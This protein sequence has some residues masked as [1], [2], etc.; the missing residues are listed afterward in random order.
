MSYPTQPRST[1]W[2]PIDCLPGAKLTES[3]LLDLMDPQEVQLWNRPTDLVELRTAV[4]DEALPALTF[5]GNLA[6]TSGKKWVDR[7][8][9]CLLTITTH[10][11]VLQQNNPETGEVINARYLH[12]SNLLA[13]TQ[14]EKGTMFKN[15]RL[16]LGSVLGEIYLIFRGDK[17]AGNCK[18]VM[19]CLQQ[20]VKRKQWEVETKLQK[21]DQ[22][23]ASKASKKVGVDAILS[24]SE[25][26]H[27]QAA[28]I[29][30]SAFAGD[31]DQLLEEAAALVKIIQKYVA[32]VDKH[33]SSSGG[34]EDKDN[35]ERLTNMLSN[36]GMTSALRKA[37]YK[38]REDAYYAT[39]AR[40]L[41]DFLRPKIKKQ[42]MMTLT[43]VY[44]LYNR[45]R[46]TNLLSPEDL[47]LAID[48]METISVGLSHY[49]FP[50]GLRVL[51]DAA[52]DEEKSA[53][54]L[55]ELANK[56]SSGGLT[57]QEA[58]H[59]LH[60]SVLLAQEQLQA[61][62]RNGSLVRDE[63]ESGIRFF[64]NFFVEWAGRKEM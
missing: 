63:T 52:L 3:G 19:Q 61:A 31:A 24:R 15:P 14:M 16:L 11:I 32:T 17:A 10:R 7:S 38:G 60:V 37:D 50:S 23:V 49:E 42:Q 55:V 35:H 4:A 51:Q 20:A 57:C 40:Q 53:L 5:G 58:S 56:S 33:E 48:Q 62:E 13:E 18:D 22:A 8:V 45:A 21:M 25:A 47:L 46:G 43:D 29:T 36:M 44:C 54:R 41:A 6:N 26:R 12:L 59:L 30:T 64:P 28:S 39:L 2:S 9:D 34:E 27:K 1:T